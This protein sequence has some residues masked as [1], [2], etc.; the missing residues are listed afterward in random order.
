MFNELFLLDL[1]LD[2]VTGVQEYYTKHI[3]FTV[4]EMEGLLEFL[5]HSTRVVVTKAVLATERLEN[6][7]FFEGTVEFKDD[8]ILFESGSVIGIDRPNEDFEL[9]LH[10]AADGIAKHELLGL[11]AEEV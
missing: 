3:A 8:V 4:S 9:R 2:W 11:A 1:A 10:A 6:V 5:N 7:S